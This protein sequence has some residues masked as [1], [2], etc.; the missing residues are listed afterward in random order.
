MGMKGWLYW[1]AWYF[2]FSVFMLISVAVMT[3]LFHVKVSGDQAVMNYTDPSVTFVFLLLFSLSVMT[4]CFVVSTF[5]SKS[6]CIVL[7]A[8]YGCMG[9]Y[10]SQLPILFHDLL[11][12][13][14]LYDCVWSLITAHNLT[15]EKRDN[16]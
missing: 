3:V 12:R 5:C 4:L 13:S 14:C 15:P 10:K 8:L 11:L 7:Y 2:K 9:A 16:N 1:S 6:M